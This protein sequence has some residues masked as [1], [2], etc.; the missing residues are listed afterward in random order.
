[1]WKSL[2]GWLASVPIADPIERKSAIFLQLVLAYEGLFV[3]FN[4]I[5]R[6][7]FVDSALGGAPD[8]GNY[9][10]LVDNLTDAGITVAAWVA[11]ALVRRGKK[12]R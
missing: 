3:P 11:F 2:K 7:W 6:R 1:M 10:I 5:Y 4:K 8:Y 9:A 12:K